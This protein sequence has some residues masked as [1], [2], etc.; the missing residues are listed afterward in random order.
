MNELQ[1]LQST[2]SATSRVQEAST[3]EWGK[4]ELQQKHKGEKTKQ[5]ELKGSK[6]ACI[7]QFRWIEFIIN[8]IIPFTLAGE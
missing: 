8:T 6:S 2:R 1:L 7:M 4:N 5:T 3:R